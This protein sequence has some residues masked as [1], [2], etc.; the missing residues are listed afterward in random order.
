M[1]MLT[2]ILL[3]MIDQSPFNILV[4]YLILA[5]SL[6]LF[7]FFLIHVALYKLEFINSKLLRET[8]KKKAHEEALKRAEDVKRGAR[9]KVLFHRSRPI[10]NLF[11]TASLVTPQ[12]M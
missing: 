4:I 10:T 5:L 9:G 3:V 12:Q 7:A 1:H 8:E 11:F 2:V 6:F